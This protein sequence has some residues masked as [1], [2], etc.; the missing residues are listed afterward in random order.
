[1]KN[2]NVIEIMLNMIDKV[3]NLKLEYDA[4]VAF[5]NIKK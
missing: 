4:K 3:Q 5:S 2:E 1:M